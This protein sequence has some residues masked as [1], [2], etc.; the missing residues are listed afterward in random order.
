MRNL[1]SRSLANRALIAL[2]GLLSTVGLV[3]AMQSATVAVPAGDAW[4]ATAVLTSGAE[5]AEV[6]GP[7]GIGTGGDD[8]WEWSIGIGSGGQLSIN[9]QPAGACIPMNSH[10]V[11]VSAWRSGPNW[12][13]D[14]EVRDLVTNM[15]RGSLDDYQMNGPTVQ[16]TAS[17]QT[18]TSLNIQ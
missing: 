3:W 4:T 17:A 13:C 7:G 5:G 6:Y 12:F 18:L 9:G 2:V 8:T 10:A 1:N 14:I 15:V 16:V 11:T